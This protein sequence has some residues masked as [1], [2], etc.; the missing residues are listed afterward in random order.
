MWPAEC[1]Q[2]SVGLSQKRK[3]DRR[4]FC[5]SAGIVRQVPLEKREI[6]PVAEWPEDLLPDATDDMTCSSIAESSLDLMGISQRTIIQAHGTSYIH[7][8]C[9]CRS[10]GVHKAKCVGS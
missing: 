6:P 3:T 4:N 7:A 2:R 10:V 9:R 5:A 8:K 1:K